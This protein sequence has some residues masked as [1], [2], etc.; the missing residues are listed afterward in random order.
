MRREIKIAL[1]GGELDALLDLPE[2]KPRAALTLAHGAGAGMTHGF[3]EE[4]ATGLVSEGFAVL[5][6]QFPY[7]QQGR[8]MPGAPK[9]A[10]V[11]IVEAQ[12]VLAAECPEVPLFVSG[13]SYGGRMSSMGAAE[14]AFPLARGLISFGY[15]LHPPEKPGLDR[16]KHLDRIEIPHLI[17]QGDRDE[18]AQLDLLEGVCKGIPGI[19]LHILKGADHSFG[20]LKSSGRTNGDVMAELVREAARFMAG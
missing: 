9:V 14:G 5:R 3:M 8:K 17:L 15:P 16:A 12:R 11:A 13:K 19:T 20:V 2:G 4:L 7:M 10:V 1:E 6:F 18:L